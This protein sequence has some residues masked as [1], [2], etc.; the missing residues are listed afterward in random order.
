MTRS[1]ASKAVA[2]VPAPAAGLR[3]SIKGAECPL[4]LQIG[5]E[6]RLDA[7]E[8]LWTLAAAR[9]VDRLC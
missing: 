7:Q 9:F 2:T 3:D 4:R 1:P 8:A 6:R 5:F